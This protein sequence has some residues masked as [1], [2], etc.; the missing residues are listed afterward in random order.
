MT[1]ASAKNIYGWRGSGPPSNSSDPRNTWNGPIVT[2]PDGLFHIYDPIYREGSLGGP[3][4][5]LHGVATNVTGR[6]D[7][8]SRPS[9]PIERG[10]NPAFVV[11][12]GADG[13][14]VYS[15]WMGGTVRLAPGPD[16][17]FRTVEG[18]SYPGGNPAPLYHNGA[19]YM[20]NQKT[21]EIFTT[22]NIT[23][24]AKWV[25]FA[26]IARP[27][28]LPGGSWY[29]TEDPYMWIDRHGNWHMCVA[30][31]QRRPTLIRQRRT[32]RAHRFSRGGETYQSAFR[33]AARALISRSH[34]TD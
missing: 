6:W 20:T 26:S 17:P 12:K 11:F 1:P 30:R 19:F 4:A 13:A 9:I 16:G 8:T 7:W 2:G 10:E 28:Q 18:F 32:A 23:S 27:N 29:H 33:S 5:I 31:C 34:C 14:E 15:L 21:T 22:P 3:T 24:G 25:T